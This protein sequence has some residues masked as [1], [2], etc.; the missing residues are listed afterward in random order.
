[1]FIDRG[2]M[3]IKPGCVEET[4]RL[5]KAEI[6]R[7]P[8]P[9]RLYTAFYGPLDVLVGDTAAESQGATEKMWDEWGARPENPKFFEQW[10]RLIAG[11][12][13]AELWVERLG[14]PDART[15]YI[16]RRT[17]TVRHGH[18]DEV[19]QLVQAEVER[20]HNT[21]AYLFTAVYGT[22]EIYLFDVREN[23]IQAIDKF[24]TDWGS[25]PEAA[26]FRKKWDQHVV[27]DKREL[28]VER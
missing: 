6:E 16:E 26:A 19:L 18:M 8:L 7:A 1:M 25:T 11:G 15:K 21:N 14:T 17:I 9:L 23:D 10:N 24:W 3:P 28:W 27:S 2:T 22:R 12:G 20:I 13:R 4:I 5:W